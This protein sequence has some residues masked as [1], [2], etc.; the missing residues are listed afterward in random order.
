MA[1]GLTLTA[2]VK[3]RRRDLALLRTL[4]F[5]RRQLAASVGWQAS[6]GVAIGALVGAPVGVVIGRF[7]GDLFA[8]QINAVPAPTVP[9]VLIVVISV[10]APMVANLVAAIPGRV[11]AHTSTAPLLRAE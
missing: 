9:T 8:H 11:A 10:A 7:R 4:A 5:T 1:L 3:R 6:V 2:S